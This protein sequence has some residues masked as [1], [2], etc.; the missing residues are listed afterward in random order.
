MYPA[1]HPMARG[2]GAT[3]GSMDLSK[4]LWGDDKYKRTAAG[5]INTGMVWSERDESDLAYGKD[6]SNGSGRRRRS[7][8]YERTRR[9]TDS[10]PLRY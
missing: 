1:D 5:D 3:N 6:Y 9:R 7:A 4:D 2:P 10:D 8:S